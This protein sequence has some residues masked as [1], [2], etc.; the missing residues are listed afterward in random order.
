[1]LLQN[2]EKREKTQQTH[3]DKGAFGENSEGYGVGDIVG[4]FAIDIR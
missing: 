3:P 2:K 1:M 4:P